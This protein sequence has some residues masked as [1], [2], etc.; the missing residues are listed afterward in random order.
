M[1]LERVFDSKLAHASYVVGDPATEKA[2][3]VDPGRD[4]RPYLQIAADQ[5]YEIAAVLETHI[6]ADFAS[7]AKELAE[8]TGATLYVSDEGPD[9][10]KYAFADGRSVIA[11]TDGAR[12][13]LGRLSFEVM[14]TPGHTPEHIAFKLFDSDANL[15]G[16]FTGDFLFVSDV[17]RPDLLERAAGF[18]NT[19]REGAAVLF[20]TIK[21]FKN[22]IPAHATIWPAH[23]AG[24]ACGKSLGALP[25]TTMGYE[26]QTNWAFQ[27]GSSEDFIEEVLQGQPDPPYYF[28]EMKRINKLG[29]P[30]SSAIGAPTRL[31]GESLRQQ[32]F[33][34]AFVLDTRAT[35]TVAEEALPN[36]IN[37]PAGKSFTTWAG[38]LVPYDRQILLIAADE[39]S[40]AE[41]RR[42]LASIGIDDVIGWA[43]DDALKMARM[44]K[45]PLPTIGKC[46]ARAAWDAS[47]RGEVQ[48][49]DVRS[50]A[51]FAGG[52]LPGAV[53]IP[54]G[55]LPNR[56][57]E[58]DS[59]RPVVTHCGGGDRSPIA[60]S[61]LVAAGFE[62]VSD[63]AGG[64]YE[65]KAEGLPM[66]SATEEPAIV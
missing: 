34:D 49:L 65:I 15:V 7:G 5:G 51:E 42:D 9:E 21:R 44:A 45:G 58:L 3:V 20:E 53:N 29:S 56:A 17:G 13:V 22:E 57:N 40:A 36:A 64:A 50:A 47:Q 12:I 19:M 6:H 11:V 31:A 59:T 37:I 48:I 25:S 10:W 24:S 1:F 18:Q 60:A 26:M 62:K 16:V 46:S 66:E 8:Q 33:G 30:N 61:V 23:G 32:L 2:A 43:G 39:Q 41:V 35:G 38:W 63:M 55:Q 27:I 4:V 28:K 54:I 52:H 14:A